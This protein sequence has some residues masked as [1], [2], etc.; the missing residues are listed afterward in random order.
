[1]K[2]FWV[3]TY[4]GYNDQIGRDYFDNEG[5]A[6]EAWQIADRPMFLDEVRRL[7]SNI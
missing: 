3:L 5:E 7:E 2:T 1:M 4:L 6:R